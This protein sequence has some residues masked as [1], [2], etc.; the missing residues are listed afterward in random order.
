MSLILLIIMPN[1]NISGN[2]PL[3]LFKKFEKKVKETKKTRPELTN[4][5]KIRELIE[6]YVYG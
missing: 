4:C 6:N 1:V 2:I 5:K 3:D